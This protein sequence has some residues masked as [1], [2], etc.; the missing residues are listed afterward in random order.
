MYLDQ[1][2]LPT[3]QTSLNISA[4]LIA[5][6]KILQCSAEELEQTIARELSENPALEAED[7][8]Q[9]LHCG[10]ALVA[11]ACPAC[12]QTPA[13]ADPRTDLAAW[14]EPLPAGTDL[15]G[16]NDDETDPLD[17]VFTRETLEEYLL[18]QMGAIIPDAEFP[19]ADYLVGNLNPHG[20]L[21]TTV[22]EAAETLRVP[23]CAVERVLASLQSLDPP[24]IGARDLRECLLIQMQ[25]F[26]ERGEAPPLARR[27]IED[28]LVRLGE[29]HFADIARQ[30]G[31]GMPQVKLAWLFIKQNLSP[32]PAHVF[33]SG[34]VPDVGLLLSSERSTV[35]RPDVIIR[36]TEQGFEAEVVERRRFRF[37]L[38]PLYHTLSQRGHNVTLAATPLSE[39]ERQHIREYASRARFFID[40]IRQ[41]WDT[42]GTISGA[43]IDCQRE[44]LAY[45]VRYLRPLTRG[46]LAAYLGLHEST[47]S[48]ATANKYVLL[49][50][51]RTVS[52]D[53][54]FDGSLAAKD[55]MR[56]LIAAEDPARPYSDED[57][58]EL[59]RERGV[60]LARRTVAKYREAMGILPSR[61][62][63]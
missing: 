27:L 23:E 41:R 26:E 62:R 51:G 32:Y 57:L 16:G 28:Y 39:R 47:V 4:K 36:A 3:T 22:A 9:C 17:F 24:G 1:A 63:I 6:I 20:Y 11:G 34:D 8:G 13:A 37:N 15:T 35:V 50:C 12:D 59:M 48:R 2:Q 38:S 44:Y 33:E 58:A 55:L 43:L 54:F 53:D 60:T 5:S 45:G 25:L 46:D 61:F 29:H 31:V 18:R 7:L 21:V 10:A 30:L 52:F 49:P 56:E 40:C 19:I 42:L 14:D